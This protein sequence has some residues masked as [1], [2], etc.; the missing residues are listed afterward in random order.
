M[1]DIKRLAEEAH[2]AIC[3]VWPECLQTMA[4]LKDRNA[5]A[6]ID[7]LAAA[8]EEAERRAADHVCLDPKHSD[9]V[10]ILRTGMEA[11]DAHIAALTRQNEALR[12][13][14]AGL[15]HEHDDAAADE[16]LH[17]CPYS[18]CRSDTVVIA[19]SALKETP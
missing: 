4:P 8:G 19:R 14:L 1:S 13:A 16:Y 11:L 12:G 2:H 5:H 3:S 17:P 18:E 15:L 10:V 9:C 7:A 6:A